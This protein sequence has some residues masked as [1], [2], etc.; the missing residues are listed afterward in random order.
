MKVLFQSSDKKKTLSKARCHECSLKIRSVCIM[1]RIGSSTN[2]LG[3]VVLN[4]HLRHF[5]L[6]AVETQER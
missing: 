4:G 2:V 3:E 6:D 1:G 5:T